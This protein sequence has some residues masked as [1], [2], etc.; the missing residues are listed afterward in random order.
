MKFFYCVEAEIVPD[1]FSRLIMRVIE[2]D[3]SHAFILVEDIPDLIRDR[4][5]LHPEH[6]IIFEATVPVYRHRS[7]LTTNSKNSEIRGKVEI[8]VTNEY[9]AL[10]WLLGNMGKEY[11]FSQCMGFLDLHLQTNLKE[12]WGNGEGKGVCSELCARFGA[13]NST[14]PELFNDVNLDY[15]TPKEGLDLFSKLHKLT[16]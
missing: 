9:L 12:I 16:F 10:G 1:T 5:M 6:G 8:A 14:R 15:I 7:I 13:T 4:H 2:A 11:S 3:Y